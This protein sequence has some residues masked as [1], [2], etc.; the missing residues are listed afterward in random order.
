MIERM[1]GQGIRWEGLSASE[2]ES[3]FCGSIPS[4][5]QRFLSIA[6][7]L[8]ERL[9]HILMVLMPL[10]HME[11]HGLNVGAVSVLQ[12]SVELQDVD[13]GDGHGTVDSRGCLIGFP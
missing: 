4:S 11:Q 2:V 6:Q 10:R 1:M 9:Q 7:P 5:P 12:P 13:S 3:L 8:V